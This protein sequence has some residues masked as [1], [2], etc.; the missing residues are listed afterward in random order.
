MEQYNKESHF[1][2]DNTQ[3]AQRL[4]SQG[5]NQRRQGDAK[6]HNTLSNSG[7]LS[8]WGGSGHNDK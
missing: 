8:S 3:Q 5:N 7:T 2:E 4:F 1:V 6:N